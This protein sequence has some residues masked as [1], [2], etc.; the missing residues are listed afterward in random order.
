MNKEAAK[1]SKSFFLKDL[2][3]P[4]H[5]SAGWPLLLL[6]LGGALGGACGGA[7][8]FVNGKIFRSAMPEA[9]KHALAFL[10]GVAAVVLYILM[11][12]I[13]AVIFPNLFN[14]ANS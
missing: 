6:V 1:S 2:T 8:Y 13:L 9:K 3:W 5:L 11:V 10:V 7:A 4:Q 12:G 14:R